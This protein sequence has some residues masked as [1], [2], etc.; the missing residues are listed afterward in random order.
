MVW[1]SLAI[2]QSERLVLQS[3]AVLQSER[4]VLQSLAVLQSERLVLQSLVVLQSE[5]RTFSHKGESEPNTLVYA[6]AKWKAG[7][8]CCFYL[9]SE[10]VFSEL[11]CG[12]WWKKRA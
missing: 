10:P 6:V 1:Q 9:F 3:A 12:W 4:L 11:V 2:L 7:S 5:R 8:C